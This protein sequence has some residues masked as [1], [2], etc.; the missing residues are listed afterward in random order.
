[1]FKYLKIFPALGLGLALLLSPV[2]LKVKA[3]DI[4]RPNYF[5]TQ[6]ME[7]QAR[8]YGEN[9][10]KVR[11]LKLMKTL[12][13]DGESFVSPNTDVK[14]LYNLAVMSDKVEEVERIMTDFE[15]DY[16]AFEMFLLTGDQTLASQYYNDPTICFKFERVL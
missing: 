14:G 2:T 8:I 13:V 1:M 4:N 3:I 15:K 6:Y 16:I 11:D 7:N 12:G 9:L 10:K 5:W